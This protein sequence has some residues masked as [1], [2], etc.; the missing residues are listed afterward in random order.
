[1]IHSRSDK[2]N[3][4]NIV[5]RIAKICPTIVISP[6]TSS[7]I[8]LLHGT[9]FALLGALLGDHLECLDILV[10]LLVEAH[11]HHDEFHDVHHA[12]HLFHVRIYRG[13]LNTV[14]YTLS[15]I[16]SQRERIRL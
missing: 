1:M 9:P 10:D 2:V 5:H 7:S 15:Y 4:C 11:V 3:Y 12:S 14:R 13:G 6:S 16:E 8:Y